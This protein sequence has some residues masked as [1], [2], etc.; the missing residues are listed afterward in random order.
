MFDGEHCGWCEAPVK[1]LKETCMITVQHFAGS[2]RQFIV[3]EECAKS[4]ESH[5]QGGE[6]VPIGSD[7]K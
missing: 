5:I 4:I 1:E 3:C 7:L 6:I 2:A